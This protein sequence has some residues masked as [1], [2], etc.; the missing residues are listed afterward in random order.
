MLHHLVE[1]LNAFGSCLAVRG[2]L[3]HGI[4]I[5]ID[6][7]GG[8]LANEVHFPEPRHPLTD[9]RRPD[10]N[11]MSMLAQV[12]LFAPV[13]REPMRLTG[14]LPSARERDRCA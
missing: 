8:N 11:S 13:D 4:V 9:G 12:A 3:D 2:I 5:R 10:A 7:Q 1:V 6:I 14:F